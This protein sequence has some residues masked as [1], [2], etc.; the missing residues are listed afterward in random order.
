V[1]TSRILNLLPPV[2]TV[3]PYL[4]DETGLINETKHIKELGMFGKLAIHPKQVNIINDIFTPTKSEI[5]EA[6]S[7]VKAFLEAEKEGVASIRVN[8]KFVDYP[9]YLKSKRIIELA[10]ILEKKE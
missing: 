3:F 7:I 4:N 8:N 2:D 9:L 6:N 10:K 1:L 5:D